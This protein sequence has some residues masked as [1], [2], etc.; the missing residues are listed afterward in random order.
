MKQVFQESK[1]LSLRTTS[2]RLGLREEVSTLF[3]LVLDLSLMES[4]SRVM[5]GLIRSCSSTRE[6][7]VS[8]VQPWG[9]TA[10]G[11]KP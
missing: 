6:L 8:L 11:V 10:V 2:L 9:G 7:L 5:I 4:Q 1:T 3:L